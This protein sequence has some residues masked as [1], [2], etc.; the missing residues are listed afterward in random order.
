MFRFVFK[1][2]RRAKPRRVRRVRTVP[3]GMKGLPVFGREAYLKHKED[4]RAYITARV[5]YWNQYY[6]FHYGRIAIKDNARSW[7]SCSTLGNLNFS[8]LLRFLPPE[9]ADYVIVHELCHL[10]EHNHGPRFWALVA[11]TTPDYRAL[12]RELHTYVLR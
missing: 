11:Q 6:D 1:T 12:R 10:R 8:Y 4:A 2:R 7:G 5:E 3:P 9:L